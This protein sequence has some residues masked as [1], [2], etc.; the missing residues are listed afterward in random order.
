MGQDVEGVRVWNICIGC[1]HIH[2]V[3]MTWGGIVPHRLHLCG[4]RGLRP[5]G[6]VQVKSVAHF[7]VLVL[8]L[9]R[10]LPGTLHDIKRLPLSLEIVE[11]F[12]VGEEQGEQIVDG[13]VVV[14]SQNLPGVLALSPRLVSQ[15]ISGRGDAGVG[16]CFLHSDWSVMRSD[17]KSSTTNS[18]LL[19]VQPRH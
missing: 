5:D 17:E 12:R 15:K 7:P 1:L 6:M 18:R 13:N 4:S 2:I 10:V 8:R 11:K 16:I 19:T 9:G 14:P 3:N